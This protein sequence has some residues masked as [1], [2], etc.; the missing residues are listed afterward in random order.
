MESLSINENQVLPTSV[1]NYVE[2]TQ[3]PL[4]LDDVTH[5][6][7][8]NK[9][10]YIVTHQPKS[11]LASPIIHQGKLTGILYLENNLTTH[12]FTKDR[13][14][15]LQI[16][17]AQAAISIENTR[18]YSTL[19]RRVKER[20]QQLEDKN[21]QLQAILGELQ[22]TQAQLI[23]NE[24]MS[25]LG[26]LVAGVAHEINNPINFIFGN[27]NH[28]SEYTK[29]LLEIIEFYQEEYPNSSKKIIDKINE[30]DLDFIKSDIPNLLISMKTGA[31]R[32]R[33]IVKSLRNFSRLDESTI[34][35]VDIHEGIENTLMVLQ[36]K[37]RDIQVIK[38]YGK[39]PQII[40]DASQ[41]NQVFLHLLT[42]S[43]DALSEQ[44]TSVKITK[45]Q[46]LKDKP[47]IWISTVVDSSQQVVIRIT[48]NGIG[49]DNEI[50]SKVFDPFFTTKPVGK[51][52]GL[53]LSISYQ[54]VTEKHGGSLDFISSPEDGTTFIIR[55]PIPSR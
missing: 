29:S 1:I 22:R 36:Q 54:I 31:E 39:L 52:T 9:D 35:E 12:A 37:I 46:K 24:K 8:F 45:N 28:V 19:E 27:L 16:L 42:N 53:G 20:T 49:I 11:I 38:E 13:L 21:H 23:H 18:L 5:A 30:D 7:N 2:R 14:E 15:L 25:S 32:V 26:Q 4:V 34:K 17:S 50:K 51:G 6:E 33:D 3:T 47:T 55:L 43:I 10:P 44:N 40:C 41:M 48:D